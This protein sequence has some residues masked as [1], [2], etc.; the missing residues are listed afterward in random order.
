MLAYGVFLAA[1]VSTLA[2]W[3]ALI[4]S[5]TTSVYPD[6]YSG[7]ETS[8]TRSQD[9]EEERAERRRVNAIYEEE[10]NHHRAA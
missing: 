10:W 1:M 3:G 5:M 2:V 8:L 4:W 6:G 7:G 9:E